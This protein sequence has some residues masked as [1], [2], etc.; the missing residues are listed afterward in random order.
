MRKSALSALLLSVSL[1]FAK[2]GSMTNMPH[3]MSHH[4]M[5]QASQKESLFSQ[6]MGLMHGPMMQVPF[7][8]GE[9]L[10]FN[11]LANMIPHHKGAILS[12][13][14][15]LQHSKD[16]KIRS[17]AE[18]IIK[19]Q[20]AEIEEFEAL[21]PKLRDERVQYTQKDIDLYNDR[22]KMDMQEMGEMM[23]GVESSGKLEE[24]FLRAMIPH[25]Q[26]AIK[27]SEQILKYTQNKNIRAIAERI[28]KVQQQEIE[29]FRE[30]LKSSH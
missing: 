15:I 22:A 30:I 12:S 28:I 6:M 17:I 13:E 3:S 10:D 19:E 8:A 2:E 24:D 16:P 20:K 18:Q 29:Q 1:G 14:F 4:G 26:G 25:H 27:S 11:F 23:S 5:E 21:S 7:E 9:N